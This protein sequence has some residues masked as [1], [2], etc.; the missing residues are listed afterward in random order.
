MSEN[1]NL[2]EIKRE[3]YK[4]LEQIWMTQFYSKEEFVYAKFT[5]MPICYYQVEFNRCILSRF[6]VFL[7]GKFMFVLLILPLTFPIKE[8]ILII[9]V[10]LCICENIFSDCYYNDLFVWIIAQD[11]IDSLP[12]K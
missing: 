11:K 7:P 5:T 9:H 8:A 6:Q 1:L 10:G 12:L 3:M 4:L 2:L